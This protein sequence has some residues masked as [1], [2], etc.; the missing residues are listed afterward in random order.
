MRKPIQFALAAALSLM[1]VAGLSG[2]VHS[3]E[4]TKLISGKLN[5]EKDTIVSNVSVYG[6]DLTGLSLEEATEIAEK[7]MLDLVQSELQIKAEKNEANVWGIDIKDLGVSWNKPFVE[8]QL[9]GA[10][11]QGKLLDRYKM[12]KDYQ[13]SPLAVDTE[14][15]IDENAILAK[16]NEE[17]AT[18]NTE[19]VDAQVTARVG[20]VTEW[21]QTGESRQTIVTP[22]SNGYHYDFSGCIQEFVDNARQGIVEDSGIIVLTPYEE[23]LIPNFTTER[24]EGFSVIGFCKTEYAIPV[25]TST[26]NREANL[27]TGVSFLDGR[28][29]APGELISALDLYHECTAE[30]GYK[31]AGTYA[32]GGHSDELGGGLCQVTTTIY[33]AVLEAELEV[34]YRRA[35]SSLISYVNPSLDAMVHPQSGQD[36]QFRNSS[37]D[38]IILEGAI[39]KHSQWIYIWILGHEDHAPGHKVVY[40]SCLDGITVAG[41]NQNVDPGLGVGWKSRNFTVSAYP[42]NGATSHLVKH[43]YEDDVEVSATIISHDVYRPM[44]GTVNVAPDCEVRVVTN[45]DRGR[46]YTDMQTFFKNGVSVGA[47]PATW[48]PE[49]RASFNASMASIGASNGFT[50]P[51]SGSAFSFDGRQLLSDEIAPPEEEAEEGEAEE[52]KAEE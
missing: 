45:G 26:I 30:N 14:L 13:A 46:S 19:P 42:M 38:D 23:E 39:D 11:L 4:D 49:E 47:N 17:L 5:L 22:G 20:S 52:E 31:I 36:F 12:A 51:D 33:D 21:T 3:E 37:S 10:V 9:A 44:T 28:R 43:V 7:P 48:S 35:H 2:V 32:N 1:C 50:W 15:K 8:E 25:D 40:E 29:F 24:A 41:L 34:V 27:I 18:W 6:Q 16:V